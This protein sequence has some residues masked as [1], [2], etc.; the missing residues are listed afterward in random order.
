MRQDGECAAWMDA[1]F[2]GGLVERHA[3]GNEP[4]EFATATSGLV[5][6]WAAS[7]AED[8]RHVAS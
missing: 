8:T 1:R 5:C 7:A 2:L 4:N 3:F 6:G